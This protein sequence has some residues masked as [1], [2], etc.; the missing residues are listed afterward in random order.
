[1]GDTGSRAEGGEGMAGEKQYKSARA[2]QRGLEDYFQSIRRTVEVTENV[3]TGE[4]DEK[5]HVIYAPVKV[6]NDKGE[7]MTRQ[8]YFQPPSVGG[9][10]RHLGI[11]RRTWVRYG[12]DKALGP[13]IQSAKEEMLRWNEEELLLR[14]GKNVRGIVFNLEM[15]YYGREEKNESEGGVILLPPVEEE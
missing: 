9:A 1:M 11:S 8:E 7:V 14:E 4:R 3:P 6:I 5:G 12:Q 2:L 13:V 10:C 15:N